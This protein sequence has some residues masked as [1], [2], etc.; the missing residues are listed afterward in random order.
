LMD[1]KAGQDI[2]FIGLDRINAIDDSFNCPGFQPGTKCIFLIGFSR[3]L[4]M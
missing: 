4:Y 2:H 1:Y 3:N